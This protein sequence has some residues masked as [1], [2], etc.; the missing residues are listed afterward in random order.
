MPRVIGNYLCSINPDDWEKAKQ[1]G[2]FGN[3]NNDRKNTY[4]SIIQDLISIQPDDRLFFHIINEKK[5]FG[6]Y[7]AVCT[8]FYDENNCMNF[9][10]KVPNRILFEHHPNY[11]DIVDNESYVTTA[12]LN[13]LIETKIIKDISS[14]ERE[15][16]APYHSVKRIFTN[17]AEQ[18][19][20]TLLKNTRFSPKRTQFNKYSRPTGSVDLS[21]K[22][23]RVGE[24]EFSIKAVASIDLAKA[25]YIKNTLTYAL[26]LQKNFDF[27]FENRLSATLT[28]E[29]DFFIKENGDRWINCEFKAKQCD[30][31]VL[32][33]TLRYGDLIRLKH[34][35]KGKMDCAIVGLSPKKQ[36]DLKE[37]I[38][39][40]N[41]LIYPDKIINIYYKPKNGSA[42]FSKV[43]YAEQNYKI[44]E[45]NS[46]NLSSKNI[47]NLKRVFPYI[48]DELEKTKNAYVLKRALFNENSKSLGELFITKLIMFNKDNFIS[49]L[50]SYR[51]RVLERSERPSF[52]EVFPVITYDKIDSTVDRMIEIY[53]DN[54]EWRPKITLFSNSKI[55]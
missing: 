19:I 32:K 51:K 9:I 48:L 33:Q 13:E 55:L 27:I 14:I 5:V 15:Q 29:Q 41:N 42:I 2:L 24:L 10:R 23:T 52:N 22:I 21:E 16:N 35:F 44:Q 50:R 26:G 7:K 40:L 30:R 8:A 43:D 49:F 3:M 12:E 25:S 34:S 18:I 20:K 47:E 39:I 36:D 17:D 37:A 38:V 11:R 28:K 6:V 46:E 31:V 4:M 45:Y 54:F 1:I 53:N